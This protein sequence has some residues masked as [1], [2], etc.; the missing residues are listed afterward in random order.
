MSVQA[1]ILCEEKNL[2]SGWRKRLLNSRPD[3]LISKE[4]SHVI[5]LRQYLKLRCA[6]KL[7]VTLLA[8]LV[9]TLFQITESVRILTT[10]QCFFCS[11]ISTE[12]CQHNFHGNCCLLA[13]GLEAEWEI[14][15]TMSSSLLNTKDNTS[16]SH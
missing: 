13:I 6:A 2:L 1:R 14:S 16:C 3:M 10:K 11:I 15:S 7:L 5:Q 9:L 12:V 4:F 8:T